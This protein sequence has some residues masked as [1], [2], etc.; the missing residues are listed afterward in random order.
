MNTERLER[1]RVERKNANSFGNMPEIILK[2]KD[3]KSISERTQ[4]LLSEFKD[5]VFWKQYLVSN[6]LDEKK[7]AC[8]QYFQ[9]N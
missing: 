2:S 5:K 7:D 4:R 9:C 8:M 6:R 3:L 1:R